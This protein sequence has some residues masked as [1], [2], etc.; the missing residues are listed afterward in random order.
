MNNS[1]Y[2]SICLM[3]LI[4]GSIF[5]GSTVKSIAQDA[6]TYS[7]PGVAPFNTPSGRFGLFEAGTGRIYLYDDNL[8]NCVFVGQLKKL[9][10]PIEKIK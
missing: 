10:E 3:V 5:I 8:T 9:G 7:F 1:L 4:L 6:P 2:R